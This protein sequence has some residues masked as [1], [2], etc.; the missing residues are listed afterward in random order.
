D[1]DAALE[2]RAELS[3]HRRSQS[4]PEI[5]TGVGVADDRVDLRAKLLSEGSGL[6]RAGGHRLQG[7]KACDHPL[8]DGPSRPSVGPIENRGAVE[9]ERNGDA[10]SDP[11][12]EEPLELAELGRLRPDDATGV[13][14]TEITEADEGLPGEV[15]LRPVRL[16]RQIG[17][18]PELGAED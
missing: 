16:E 3:R 1:E 15:E 8:V 18:R 9:A 13:T 10:G 11:V 14:R 4:A 6:G 12:R 5:G 2:A 7:A 17:L